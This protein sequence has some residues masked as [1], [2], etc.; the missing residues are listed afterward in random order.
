M[1]LG[2]WGE[3]ELKNSKFPNTVF[4]CKIVLNIL[5]QLPI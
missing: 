2:D 3:E 4:Q 1:V 5:K